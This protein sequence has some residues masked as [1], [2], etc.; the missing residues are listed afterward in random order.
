MMMIPSSV[1]KKGLLI[2]FEGKSFW[3]APGDWAADRGRVVKLAAC[4]WEK[5]LQQGGRAG[6]KQRKKEG[7]IGVSGIGACAIAKQNHHLPF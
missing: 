7:T 5:G 2:G 6:E 3:L 1:G 4:S